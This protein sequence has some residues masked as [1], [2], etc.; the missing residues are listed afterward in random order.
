MPMRTAK[1]SAQ[2]LARLR[3]LKA[4]LFDVDGVL[5]DGALT[6]TSQGFESKS[7]HVADVSAIRLLQQHGV[8]VG[9]ITG[10]VSK[11]V[12]I[13]AK[14]LS[15]T[16]VYQ[17]SLDKVPPYEEFKALYALRDEEIAFMADG[18]LDISV[19]KKVGFAATPSNAHASVKHA[20]HYIASLPGGHG[21]V[22]EVIDLV[23]RSREPIR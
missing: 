3:A 20:S 17:G 13:R 8:R 22:K 11:I 10:H 14:E 4:F 23:L 7:F 12:E 19:L 21:A 15:I 16:D 2:M 1:L 9:I 5:T 18:V 6:F